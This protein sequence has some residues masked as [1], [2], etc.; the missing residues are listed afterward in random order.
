MS[1][2]RGSKMEA[3]TIANDNTETHLWLA[4]RDCSRFE[5]YRLE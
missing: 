5:F 4:D 2:H 3:Y 1:T